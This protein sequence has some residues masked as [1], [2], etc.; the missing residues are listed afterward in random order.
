MM[1]MTYE[2]YPKTGGLHYYRI[3]MEQQ[4]PLEQTAM[5]QTEVNQLCLVIP[6]DVTGITLI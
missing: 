5:L 4:Q 3:F 6:G 2:P 1:L